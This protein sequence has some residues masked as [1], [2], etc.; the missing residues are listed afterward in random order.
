MQCIRCGHEN[1]E[2]TKVCSGCQARLL[3][4]APTGV[5]NQSVA[6]EE[7]REYL[8]PQ[9]NYET[10]HLMTLFEV[11]ELFLDDG[12]DPEAVMAEIE[13]HRARLDAYEAGPLPDSLSLLAQEAQRLPADDFHTQVSYLLK[14]G[15][16]LY[17][18]GLDNLTLALEEAET[19]EPFVEACQALQDGNNHICLGLELMDER[20][21]QLEEILEKHPGRH[22]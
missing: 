7:G 12:V 13:A 15:V 5:P 4:L 3:R 2:G 18:Q 11:V 10:V 17:R 14:K 16:G 1:P 19:E 8:A 22:E 9:I 6:I 21:K 20:Q